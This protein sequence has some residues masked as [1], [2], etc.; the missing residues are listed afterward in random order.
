VRAQLDGRQVEEL[1]SSL[2]GL[3]DLGREG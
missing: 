1:R 2:Q 3:L